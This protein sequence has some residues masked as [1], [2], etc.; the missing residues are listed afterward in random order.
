MEIIHSGA[1]LYTDRQNIL[2]LPT[3]T[4]I[5]LP[6]KPRDH[7]QWCTTHT[8]MDKNIVVFCTYFELPVNLKIFHSGDKIQFLQFELKSISLSVVQITIKPYRSFTVVQYL[9]DRKNI[10]H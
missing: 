1:D 5:T 7:S 3:Y 6:V 10:L 2:E 9:Y 8:K 4:Y